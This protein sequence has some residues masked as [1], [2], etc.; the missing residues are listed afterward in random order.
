MAREM[1]VIV[2]DESRAIGASPSIMGAKKIS[3]M[4]GWHDDRGLLHYG[5]IYKASDLKLYQDSDVVEITAP[6][7]AERAILGGK[8]SWTDRLNQHTV[9]YSRMSQKGREAKKKEQNAYRAKFR[10]LNVLLPK[11][12]DEAIR[13]MAPESKTAYIVGLIRQDLRERGY[14]EE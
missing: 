4:N 10:Q 5:A 1:Y 12:L 14:I 2:D 7:V 13:R 11:E 6:P 8:W 3:A 9:P